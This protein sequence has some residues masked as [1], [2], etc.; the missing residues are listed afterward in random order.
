MSEANRAL[1]MLTRRQ[2]GGSPHLALFD[3]GNWGHE[4]HMPPAPIFRVTADLQA[5]DGWD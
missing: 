3:G 2:S 1:L 5:G 4:V